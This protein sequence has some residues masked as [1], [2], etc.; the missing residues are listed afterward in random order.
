MN[1]ARSTS[2]ECK[3]G[4]SFYEHFMISAEYFQENQVNWMLNWYSK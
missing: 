4:L 3:Y 2:L 1:E